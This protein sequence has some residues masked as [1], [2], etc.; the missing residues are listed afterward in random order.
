M[1]FENLYRTKSDEEKIKGWGGDGS[2]LLKQVRS[3]MLELTYGSS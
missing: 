1:K 3:L 2:G